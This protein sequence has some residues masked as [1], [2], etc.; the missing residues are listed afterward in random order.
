MFLALEIDM[1]RGPSAFVGCTRAYVVR[2]VN[3]WLPALSAFCSCADL[4]YGFSFAKFHCAVLLNKNP[5]TRK[6]KAGGLLVV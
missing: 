6:S 4:D 5:P 2:R 1:I 3:G